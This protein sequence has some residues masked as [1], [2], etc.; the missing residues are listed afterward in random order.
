VQEQFR[1][2]FVNVQNFGAVGD[3]VTDDTVAIQAAIDYAASVGRDVGYPVTDAYYNVTLCLV[4]PPGV[5]HFGIGGYA[6]IKNF[7][8]NPAAFMYRTIFLTGNL[9]LDFINTITKYA[10]GTI[11]AGS[12]VTLT[13]IAHTANF[14]VGDQIVTISTADNGGTGT[15]RVFDYMHL[16]RVTGISGAVISLQYPIDVGYA[17]TIANLGSAT[18]TTQPINIPLFFTDNATFSNLDLEA[19]DGIFPGYNA[20]YNVTFR[21]C[22]MKGRWTV[23]GNCYQ[24]CSF[25]NIRGYF[26]YIIGEFAQNSIHSTLTNSK[27]S[28]YAS[29]LFVPGTGTAPILRFQ[30]AEASRVCKFNDNSVD[31]GNL[32]VGPGQSAVTFNDAQYC[33]ANRNTWTGVNTASQITVVAFVGRSVGLRCCNNSFEFN[34]VNFQYVRLFSLLSM[35][36]ATNFGNKFNNNRLSSAAG[37]FAYSVRIDNSYGNYVQDN[38]S[39]FGATF[40]FDTVSANNSVTGNYFPGGFSTNETSLNNQYYQQNT[41]A[42][43]T[44]LSSRVKQTAVIYAVA[45]VSAPASTA[46]EIYNKPLGTSL[47]YRDTYTLDFFITPAGTANTK[48]IELKIR[49]N[50]ASTDLVLLS[51]AIPAAT[52]TGVHIGVKITVKGSVINVVSTING[53][54]AVPVCSVVAVTTPAIGQDLN[55]IFT[56][57]PGA[58]TSLSFTQFQVEFSNPYN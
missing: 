3:G 25:D 39:N 34:S 50:T 26:S 14:A 35:V 40:F 28:Y 17:G 36:D 29:P 58:S 47:R 31:V 4:C 52:T 56:A 2:G 19:P 38:T 30:I 20:C 9:A 16:N 24:Y 51:Y 5:S 54:T 1:R 33:E 15:G 55:L 10:C 44:S 53:V 57:T 45:A 49:N 6:K 21:D 27:F 43:N 32:S 7:N 37:A 48:P 18:T 13:N 46:T 22:I 41:L 42:N 11:A 12:S 23:Y 8:T